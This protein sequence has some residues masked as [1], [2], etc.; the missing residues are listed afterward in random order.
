[1]KLTVPRLWSLVIL[2]ALCPPILDAQKKKETEKDQELLRREEMENYFKKWLKEDVVYIISDDEKAT[3]EKLTTAEER[4]QFIEQFWFRRDLDP[5]TAANEFKEEHYR[6]IVY[7][8]EHFTSGDPGWMTDR[9][10]VYIIHGP[11]TSIESRPSGGSYNRPMHEGGG[12]TSTYPFEK[13]RY[14]YIEGLGSDIELEFVDSTFTGKYQLA[15]DPWEKDALLTMPGGGKTFAEEMGVST[16]ADRPAFSPAQGGAGRGAQ[17]MFA[18]MRDL[19]FARYET[20]AR[21]QKAPELKYRDLKEVVQVNIQYVNLPIELRCDYF[22][23]NDQQTLVPVTVRVRNKDLTFKPEGEVQVAKMAVYGIITSLTNRI[24]QEFEDDIITS[25]KKEHLP[26]GLQKSSV[27]QKIIPLDRKT[28][29]KLDLVVKDLRSG[30][31]GIVQKAIT[32]PALPPEKLSVSSVI[33]SDSI[34]PMP[35]IP[36]QEEMFV[37]GDVRILPNLERRFTTEMPLGVYLQVYN[38]LLDQTTLEPSLRVTFKLSK[39]G[40]L[41][42]IATDEKGESTQFSSGQRIVLLKQLS[43]ADLEPGKY[44][45]EVEVFDQLSQRQVSVSED[46]T[47]V[48]STS[49]SS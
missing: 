2:L 10:R 18:R 45:V 13:W 21:I 44:K 46:F 43:L 25:Y 41:L 5:K 47:V 16:R 33:L 40:N 37:L 27:Y 1:M 42:R 14:K 20:H 32:P 35:D 11:P 30:H 23:L 12:T 31:I 4:E 49:V 29:Y 36:S 6:R 19:P 28:P 22:K 34:Q 8:N 26:E 9:G 3:F 38:A 39:D 48:A 24:V 7:A 15:V 17:V